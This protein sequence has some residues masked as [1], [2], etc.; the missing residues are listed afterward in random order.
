MMLYAIM[1]VEQAKLTM[2]ETLGT[3]LNVI[4]EKKQVS[5]SKA[6]VE[7]L[8]TQ[9]FCFTTEKIGGLAVYTQIDE[10]LKKCIDAQKPKR[11]E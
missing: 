5:F 8:A 9:W 4:R 10:S 2:A 6:E 3:L 11:G 1:S 7:Q